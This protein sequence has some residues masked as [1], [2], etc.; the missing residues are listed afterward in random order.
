M[1]ATS[2]FGYLFFNFI[3]LWRIGLGRNVKNNLG[4]ERLFIDFR[5]IY[6]FDVC[7]LFVY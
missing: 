4:L 6:R 7:R 2:R 1:V 3:Y 5:F